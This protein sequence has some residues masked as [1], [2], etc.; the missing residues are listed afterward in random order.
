MVD[1]ISSLP[2]GVLG[3]IALELGFDVENLFGCCKNTASMRYNG[4]ALSLWLQRT[5]QGSDCPLEKLRSCP[6]AV[7][8]ESN[9]LIKAFQLLARD[10][11]GQLPSTSS[12]ALLQLAV[13]RSD[14]P[15]LQIILS[16]VSAL[17]LSGI[18]L[19]ACD[20]GRDGIVRALLA[21]GAKV[22]TCD[23]LQVAVRKGHATVVS[24][25]IESGMIDPRA[26]SDSAL[27]T[28][29]KHGKVVCLAQL[30]GAGCCPQSRQ[31]EALC[32]SVGGGHVDAVRLLLQRGAD[33]AARPGLLHMA[34][35]AAPPQ[36]ELVALL[37]SAGAADEDG[38]ALQH[39]S[40]SGR[41]QAVHL[42]LHGP[43][44]TLMQQPQPRYNARVLSTALQNSIIHGKF[45]HS[46]PLSTFL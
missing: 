14:L 32:L 23:P 5:F 18:L 34:L 43:G 38:A 33:P 7:R 19:K 22:G 6:I 35:G 25:L 8:I 24:A 40:T 29:A 2:Q 41:E 20:M 13:D 28:A 11:D 27:R 1:P 45:H 30:L 26:D 44:R 3:Q 37:L 9:E 42:L 16:H 36:D 17:D 10:R 12:L 4:Y 46:L 31:G 15:F 39:A 21:A